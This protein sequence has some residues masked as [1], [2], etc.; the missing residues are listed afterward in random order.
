MWR[1]PKTRSRQRASKHSASSICKFFFNLSYI[2]YLLFSFL[3]THV[4]EARNSERNKYVEFRSSIENSSEL[5]QFCSIYYYFNHLFSVLLFF[6]NGSNNFGGSTTKRY[7]PKCGWN[8]KNDCDGHCHLKSNRRQQKL[9][10]WAL[11]R[12]VKL[13]CKLQHSSKQSAGFQRQSF[14]CLLQTLIVSIPGKK[15]HSKFKTL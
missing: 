13:L 2:L 10:P 3:N 4:Q 6:R 12:I 11:S 7:R 8:R 14:D 1:A 5:N 15:I 9:S